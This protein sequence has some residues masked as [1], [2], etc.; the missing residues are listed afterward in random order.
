MRDDVASV[1]WQPGHLPPFLPP[2]NRLV[3]RLALPRPPCVPQTDDQTARRS[4]ETEP[5]SNDRSGFDNREAQS[6]ESRICG[7]NHDKRPMPM[8]LFFLLFVFFPKL[9]ER[10]PGEGG[11]SAILSVSGCVQMDCMTFRF[12][13]SKGQ[14][15]L[16]KRAGFAR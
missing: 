11:M 14:V 15:W 9:S 7:I 5:D 2:V 10:F 4:N 13:L 12:A 16:F 3:R 8:E 6:R 1:E